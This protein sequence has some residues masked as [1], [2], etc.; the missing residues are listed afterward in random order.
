[1]IRL[2]KLDNNF[3]KIIIDSLTIWFSYET[4]VAFCHDDGILAISKNIWSVTT[5]RHLNSIN[6]DKSI[7]IGN[8]EF[9]EL[10]KLELE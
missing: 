10:L 2:I 3:H 4:P 7:R 8:T 6:D 9:M 5:G 1:M